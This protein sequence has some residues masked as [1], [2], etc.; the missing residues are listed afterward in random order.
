MDEITNP[1]TIEVW[2]LPLKNFITHFKIYTG[3][4]TQGLPFLKVWE[5]ASPA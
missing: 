3:I 2:E 1:L 5:K 4:T